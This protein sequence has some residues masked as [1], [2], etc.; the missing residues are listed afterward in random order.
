MLQG[1]LS[2]I[3]GKQHGSPNH[4]PTS[5]GFG[6]QGLGLRVHEPG[7]H[8]SMLVWRR[9]LSGSSPRLAD[10]C[11]SNGLPYY[12]TTRSPKLCSIAAS[13]YTST[14]YDLMCLQ[15]FGNYSVYQMVLRIKLQVLAV[16]CQKTPKRTHALF[17]ITLFHITLR[18]QVPNNHILIQNLYYHDFYP[19]PKYLISCW[20]LEPLAY[21]LFHV[22]HS[23]NSL[24]GDYIGG[25]IGD[26]YRGY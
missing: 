20:A 6:V 14:S 12:H 8:A 5:L 15:L 21:I 26:Y 17:H 11:N 16:T 23:L 18:A 2:K 24:K 3:R 19:N 25:N 1:Y 13:L 10:V 4:V 22:N 7:M 9:V